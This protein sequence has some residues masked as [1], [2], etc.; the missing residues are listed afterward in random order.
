LARYAGAVCRFCRR[1][2]AKLFL[3]GERCYTDKCAYDR[4]GY[5]PGQHG[6]MRARKASDYGAQLREKQKV[7]RIYGILEKQFR[8]YFH[9]ALRRKGITG[10]N[11]LSLLESRLDNVVF[12]LS[13]ASS[14]SEARQ[15]VRH[16][17]VLVNGRTV[18][19]PSFQVRPQ[20]Q[21]QIREKSR[22][23]KKINE[24]LETMDRRGIPK[25]LDLDKEHFTGLV[26][27]PPSREDIAMDIDENLIVA[28]Y[29]R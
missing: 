3:K 23:L 27:S 22:Q 8:V 12:R 16:R 14:R 26:R 2:N 11:L 20:D 25:W 10:E 17:H 5:P 9:N 24:V 28:F 6:Q 21:V 18:D 13:F 1:E 29:T 7:K 4:R 15:L 19:L